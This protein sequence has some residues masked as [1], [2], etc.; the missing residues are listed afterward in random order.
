VENGYLVASVF[1]GFELQVSLTQ[2]WG[3]NSIP[4]LIISVITNI[5]VTG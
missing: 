1:G 4:Y 5:H 2:P 3:D